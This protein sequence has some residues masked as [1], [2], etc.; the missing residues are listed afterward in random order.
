MSEF[1]CSRRR[2]RLFTIDC[3]IEKGSAK[4]TCL[5][6]IK[7]L[8]LFSSFTI[9]FLLQVTTVLLF[10]FPK[11]TESEKKKIRPGG[12]AMRYLRLLQSLRSSTVAKDVS[13][14]PHRNHVAGLQRFLSVDSSSSTTGQ[15]QRYDP[16]KSRTDLEELFLDQRVRSLL[17]RLTG[18]S[19]AK[20]FATKSLDNLS[21]PKY[22]FMT[23]EQLETVCDCSLT[24]IF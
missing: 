5:P 12:R 22:R 11:T 15:Q 10:E 14:G 8:P 3:A 4:I 23:D 1:C 21:S 9:F 2:K 13:I 24:F 19:P 7:T 16:L 6:E 17:R 20:L 18:Y